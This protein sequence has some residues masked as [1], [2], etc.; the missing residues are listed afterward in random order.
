MK[1]QICAEVEGHFM[2]KD[3][4]STKLYP[5]EFSIFEKQGKKYISVTKPV[6]F[7]RVCP[8]FLRWLV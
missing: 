1:L 3:K 2:L 5:Y 7:H 4:V 6:V 8:A